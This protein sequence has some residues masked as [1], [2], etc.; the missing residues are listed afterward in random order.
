VRERVVRDGCGLSRDF[1]SIGLLKHELVSFGEVRFAWGIARQPSLSALLLLKFCQIAVS[2]W[3]FLSHPMGT[4][5][6]RD[7]SRRP[8]SMRSLTRHALDAQA[9]RASMGFSMALCKVG[10]DAAHVIRNY[11][12][13]CDAQR[14]T[15]CSREPRHNRKGCAKDE[16]DSLLVID[17]IKKSVLGAQF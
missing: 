16:G 6:S 8:E 3:Q 4:Y 11:K 2:E 5:I 14:K 9:L 12:V 7:I 17:R 1:R 15:T 13:R 10:D